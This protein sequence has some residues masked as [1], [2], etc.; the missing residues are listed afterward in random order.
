MGRRVVLLLLYG[1]LTAPSGHATDK[2]EDKLLNI[3]VWA[4]S[5]APEVIAGFEKETGIH[6]IYNAFDSNESA[7]A[8]LLT[9]ETGYDIISPTL[10]P[11]FTRL[12]DLGLLEP[13]NLALVPNTKNLDPDIIAYL[14]NNKVSLQYGI[15]YI[16]GTIGYGY[17]EEKLK[18]IFPEGIPNDS[19]ALIYDAENLKRLT[20]CG[21][22][23][24]DSP[25]DVFVTLLYYLGV[26]KAEHLP[27]EALQKAQAHLSSIHPYIDHFEAF[28]DNTTRAL[29]SG[30]ACVVQCWSSQCLA[31][32]IETQ[33]EGKPY[34]IVYVIPK[35]GAAVWFDMLAIPKKAPHPDNAAKFINY[36]LQ[37]KMAAINAEKGYVTPTVKGALQYLPPIMTQEPTFYPDPKK[38]KDSPMVPNLPF[39]HEKA[40][41]RL[42]Y[43]A[44]MEAPQP[45]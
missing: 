7:E 38:F 31:A 45:S 27:L 34:K 33:K 25:H 14:E 16:W 22:Q 11:Y 29:V 13:I 40:L 36:L 35:E 15:P 2:D 32:Q 12:K 9:G 41:T 4:D 44:K 1:L 23:L 21:V 20:Q 30:D 37:P 18:A 8:K 39:R 28:A 42:W 3:F 19:L 6:V 24:L 17:N 5:I 10:S 43:K 26:P